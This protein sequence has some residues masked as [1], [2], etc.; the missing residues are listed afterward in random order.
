MAEVSEPIWNLVQIITQLELGGAQLA[1]LY[2]AEH[3]RFPSGSRFLLFGPGGVLDK[4]AR[5][6]PAVTCIEHTYQL[7]GPGQ[8]ERQPR[9]GSRQAEQSG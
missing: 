9:H 6:I 2:E 3:S 1:T 4:R 5:K 8:R 7:H